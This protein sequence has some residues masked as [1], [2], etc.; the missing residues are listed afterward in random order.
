GGTNA[1]GNT[2]L[3]GGF[4]PI[5][6]LFDG[7]G[8]LTASSILLT[9]NDNGPQCPLG[10]PACVNIDPATGSAFD[11]LLTLTGLN[12]GG[13]YDLVLS[14]GDNSANGPNYGAGFLEAGNGNFTASIYPCGGTSFCDSNLAQR[15]GQWAVDIVGVGTAADITGGGVPEP[16]SLFLLGS[17]LAAAGLLRRKRNSNRV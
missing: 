13:T 1:A 8:G 3:A 7:T 16:G 5:L 4:D 15:N 2:I 6:S 12:V 17:G 9:Q 11:S 14:Q 10:S